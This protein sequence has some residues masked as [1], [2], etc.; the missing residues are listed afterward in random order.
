LPYVLW[1]RT[2]EPVDWRR[3]TA[4]LIIRNVKRDDH[5]PKGYVV[6]PLN[7]L[8]LQV[9]ALPSPD[10]SS[11][12]LVGSLAGVRKMLPRGFYELTL[13]FYAQVDNLPT[14]I[15]FGSGGTEE[16]VVYKFLQPSGVDWPKS[17]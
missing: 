5:S 4:S 8:N 3:I 9:E 15:P 11:A 17:G 2:P 1:L 14:L 7:P 6:D 13:N 16:K 10:G 12:F